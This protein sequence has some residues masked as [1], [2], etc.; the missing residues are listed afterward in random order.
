MSLDLVS[1]V[2]NKSAYIVPSPT[3]GPVSREIL[4]E[5][6][7]LPHFLP[8]TAIPTNQTAYPH[9]IRD[10]EQVRC[11]LVGSSGCSIEDEEWRMENG[12]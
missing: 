5:S 7:S 1:I 6:G 2:D 12:G 10:R 3:D 11:H 4:G 8:I 9:E